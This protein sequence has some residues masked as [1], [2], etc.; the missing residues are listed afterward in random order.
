MADPRIAKLASILVDYSLNVKKGEV[1]KIS[2]GIEAQDLTLECAKLILKKGAYPR[3][4]IQLPGYS[5]I[6]Y[7]YASDEQLKHYP[8]ISEFEAKNIDAVLNI[9][10]DNNTKELST[11]DPSKIGLRRK[12]TK[13]LSDIIIKKDRWCYFQYPTN[14]LA[15]DANMSL[16]EFQEFTFNSCLLDWEKE[17][18]K[19]DRLVSIL[20]KGSKV[21]IRGKDTDVSFSIKGRTAIKCCGKRNMPDGE[22]YVAPVEKTVNGHISYS[23]PAIHGGREVAGVKLEFKNGKVSKATADKNEDYLKK[24]IATDKGASY[25][26]EFGIGLNKNISRHVS[27]ILFD[28]KQYGTIHLALGMAYPKGGGRNKSAIHWDMIK[29]LRQGGEIWVDNKCIQKNGKFTFRL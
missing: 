25:L 5:Y 13:K 17:A 22:V 11:I 27:Q 26:G 18:R 15:Q 6:Y 10:C 4:D 16:Q 19:Q 9:G 8:S 24:M 20:N 12:I 1:I 23:Y 28:E 2:S 21:R 7:K 3:I 14:A 29:D